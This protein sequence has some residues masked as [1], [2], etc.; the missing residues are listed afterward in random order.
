MTEDAVAAELQKQ[1]DEI[2]R[3]RAGLCR[4]ASPQPIFI[5]GTGSVQSDTRMQYAALILAG[6]QPYAGD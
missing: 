6:A 3:L 4:L 5:G 1:A 2:K